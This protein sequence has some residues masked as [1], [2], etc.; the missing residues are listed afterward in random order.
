MSALAPGPRGVVH[1]DPSG[2]TKLPWIRDRSV[3]PGQ[4]APGRLDCPC[5]NAI[6]GVRFGDGTGYPCGR[7]G[8]VWDSYGWLVTALAPLAD[9]AT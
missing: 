4:P 1:G 9:R 6:D 5:G 8:R 2:L 7:C 3:P